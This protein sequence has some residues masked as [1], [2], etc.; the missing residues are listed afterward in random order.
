MRHAIVVS[1]RIPPTLRADVAAGHVPRRD[2]LDLSDALD[3]QILNNTYQPSKGGMVAAGLSQAIHAFRRRAEYDVV[4]TDSEHVGIP[5]ALLFKRAGVRKRHIMIAHWL[6][7][8]KKVVLFRGFRLGTHV[9]V[10]VTY[11]ATQQRVALERLSLPAGQVV[12]ILHPADHSFWHP[13]GHR[14]EGVIC[15]A[16]LEFRDYPTLIQAAGSLD[17]QVDIAA[18]SPWSQRADMSGRTFLPEN[19]HVGRRSYAE[20]RELYDR[21]AF[22]VVPVFDVDFQ[23]GSLVMYEAM[24]MGK[25]IVATR[26][27]AH[28]AG[29]ILRDGETGLLVPPD[30][31]RAL[32]SAIH[33]LQRS[34]DEAARMGR[35][36]RRLV[37]DGLNHE[38]YV[39]AMLDVIAGRLP[40]ASS[41]VVRPAHI[42][43][44][45]AARPLAEPARPHVR[46]ERPA[47]ARPLRSTPGQAGRQPVGVGG[48]RT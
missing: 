23:A 7:P 33:Y 43:P 46:H 8:A 1:A 21:A 27:R 15:S 3:G 11:S 22:V 25:A 18:A 10:V 35:T 4:L 32:R 29:E 24:A 39:R 36:A 26:T 45:A 41:L 16:G 31:P 2:Y 14:A 40:D 5:L 30:D 12:R 17:L 37:E 6:S 9:D 38:Q 13:L 20:L 19:V 42:R 48:E 34:P 28:Q 47:A 44:L